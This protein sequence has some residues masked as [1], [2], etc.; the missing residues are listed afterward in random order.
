[1]PAGNDLKLLSLRSHSLHMHREYVQINDLLA[2]AAFADGA[3][4][5]SLLSLQ[6][7]SQKL[8]ELVS[9]G[10]PDKYTAELARMR[11]KSAK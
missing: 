2:A 9:S 3:A 10:V 11:I 8:Q 7:K 1:M 4:R 6:I 5:L